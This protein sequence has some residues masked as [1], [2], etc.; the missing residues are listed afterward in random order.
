VVET[1]GL[2][3]SCVHPWR[4]IGAPLILAICLALSDDTATH[5]ALM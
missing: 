5:Q 4:Y 1:Y 3:G 2:R